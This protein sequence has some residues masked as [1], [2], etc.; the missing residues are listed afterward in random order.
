MTIR[1]GDGEVDP[2]DSGPT[3]F[4]RSGQRNGKKRNRL[5]WRRRLSGHWHTYGGKNFQVSALYVASV[6]AL[7][8]PT[9]GRGVLGSTNHGLERRALEE[10][11]AWCTS[12]W[13]A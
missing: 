2:I 13:S 7:N 6:P 8:R 11:L 12:A 10:G 5:L 4:C 3:S 9:S 1:V